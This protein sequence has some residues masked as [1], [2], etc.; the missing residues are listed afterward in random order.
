MFTKHAAPL[1]EKMKNLEL[2]QSDYKMLDA[3]ATWRLAN[4]KE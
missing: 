2:G 3:L 1:I 4:V